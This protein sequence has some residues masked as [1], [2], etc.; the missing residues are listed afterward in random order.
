MA[1][2]APD[3]RFFRRKTCG[4]NVCLEYSGRV[5]SKTT[6]GRRATL[7]D[8]ARDV[9]VSTGT[10][11]VVLN[12]ARSGTSVADRTRE[13]IQASA[14]R[15]GYRPN[16]V[17]KTLQGGA[18]RTVGVIPTEANENFLLG[19]H[20]QRVLNAAANALHAEHHDM[21]V[22]TRCDQSDARG[23][24]QSVANGRMDGAIVV[25]P[26]V[27]SRLVETLDDAGFPFAV[28]D[29]DP[30]AHAAT[31]NPDDA[32]GVRLAVEHLRAL[33]HRRIAAIAGPPT[34]RSGHVRLDAFREACGPDA[35]VETGDYRAE[36]GE[37]GLQALLARDP[38]TTAVVC[39]NDETAFGALRAA[40]ALGLRTPRDL[41]VVGFDDVPTAV[42]VQPGLTTYAQPV[43]A[44]A[45]AAVAAL[46]H[47]LQTSDPIHGKTFPGRLVIR[48][49]TDRPKRDTLQ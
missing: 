22:V 37:R 46:L 26:H 5:E 3:E 36:G 47:G 32:L 19:P 43:E 20:I 21:L 35:P 8:I 17:A 34:L 6:H 15:L 30:E 31:F 12:G 27:G 18:T 44:M 2:F 10:V 7:R 16:W 29:G 40:R 33:G 48:E 11:S 13:A 9:G 38:G 49:S 28:L 23:I 25:A 1:V 39:A 14:K 24:L 42:L 41:S 45:N 4:T